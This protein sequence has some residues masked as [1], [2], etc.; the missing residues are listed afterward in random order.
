MMPITE[1]EVREIA[2][3]AR[4]SIADKDM[5]SYEDQLNKILAFVDE[6]KAI[7]TEGIIPLAHPLEETQKLR[8]DKVSE[9]NQRESY[10][11]VAPT[12]ENGL[13][14]VPQVIE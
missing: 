2:Q 4:I 3:L 14:L 6:M 5:S 12:T 10:Q 7:E 9:K 8:N 13:Y 11:S 1:K